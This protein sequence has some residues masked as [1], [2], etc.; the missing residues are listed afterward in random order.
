M[1]QP[2]VK[3]A[4]LLGKRKEK[5]VLMNYQ[6]TKNCRDKKTNHLGGAGKEGILSCL[7]R[8]QSSW[9]GRG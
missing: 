8:A 4:D 1:A 9:A 6:K 3:L 7:D 2:R 5:E